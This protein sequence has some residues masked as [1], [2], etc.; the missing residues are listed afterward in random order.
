VEAPILDEVTIEFYKD[1]KVLSR[2]RGHTSEGSSLPITFEAIDRYA[3]RFDLDD[4]EGFLYIM[5]CVDEAFLEIEAK[6]R[7]ALRRK[8][9]VRAKRH[10]RKNN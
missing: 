6:R 4:F 8:L 10:G 2:A 7:E 3:A 1:F 9:E 5:S